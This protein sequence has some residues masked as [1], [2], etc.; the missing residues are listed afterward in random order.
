ML[1]NFL[2]K[3][4]TPTLINVNAR[5][6]LNILIN[7]RFNKAGGGGNR[8]QNGIIYFFNEKVAMIIQK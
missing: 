5:I 1:S 2:K 4:I 3:N 8:E 7:V 6:N